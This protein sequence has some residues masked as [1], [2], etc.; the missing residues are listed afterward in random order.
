MTDPRA[1]ARRTIRVA[2]GKRETLEDSV[3]VT[4]SAMPPLATGAVQTLIS[5]PSAAMK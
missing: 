2:G 4:V 3:A 5:V 1:L